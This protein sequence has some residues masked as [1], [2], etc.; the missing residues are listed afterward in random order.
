MKSAHLLKIHKV[1][2]STISPNNLT[3]FPQHFVLNVPSIKV[4]Q[5]VLFF[6]LCLLKCHGCKLFDGSGVFWYVLLIVKKMNFIVIIK[7]KGK[8]NFSKSLNFINL[9]LFKTS[10]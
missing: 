9:I 7:E 10:P 3:I 6:S 8:I 2:I 5:F 1:H 4:T